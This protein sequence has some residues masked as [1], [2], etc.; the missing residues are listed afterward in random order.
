MLTSLADG[1]LLADKS[2]LS[3]ARVIALHGWGRSGLDFVRIVDGLDAL[4][5]HLPGFGITPEPP[6]AWGTVEYADALATALAGSEPV[7]VVGHS[8]GGRVA[9]R[10]AAKYPHLVSGLVLTGVPLVRLVPAPKPA[11]AF[12]VVRALAKAGLVSQVALQKQRDKHGSADYRA[13]HG[14]MRDVMV[15]TV[16]ETYGDDLT[17]ITAPARFVWGAEDTAAPADAGKV[18]SELVAGSRFVEIAG[19]GH[20]LEGDLEA[21]VRG[22]LFDLIRELKD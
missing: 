7:V 22:E 2:G 18:A 4:A 13:A 17:R 19:A 20:L 16:G 8:F 6:T 14:V 1:D 3:P 11:V 12:R 10:L 5:P 15:R 9:V 21:A